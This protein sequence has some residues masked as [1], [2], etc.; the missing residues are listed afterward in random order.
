[1]LTGYAGGRDKAAAVMG[2]GPTTLDNYRMGKTQPKF[3]ELLRLAKA[4]DHSI[5]YLVPIDM[6]S[7]A[8]SYRAEETEEDD[9]EDTPELPHDLVAVSVYNVHASAGSGLVPVDEHDEPH[10]IILARSFLRR[11]GASPEK[12]QII[13]AK[14]ESMLP[15]IP[16]GSL[17]LVDRSKTHIEEGGIFV[18]RVGEGIKVK[19]ARWRVDNARI[20][21]VSDNQLAGYPPE[22]YTRD[23]LASI[24]PL[25]RVMCI[26]RAP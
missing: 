12:S 4:A 2:V 17:L 7:W 23:E 14:G 6:I 16:D 24:V 11:L 26:M 20:D 1:M 21:L 25:G 15:T 18:F 10:D 8:M 19:R 13:F 22:T 3:L 5:N 9:N